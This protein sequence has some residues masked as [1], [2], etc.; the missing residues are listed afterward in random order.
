VA[1]G[2]HPEV[3]EQPGGEATLRSGWAVEASWS[4]IAGHLKS[5]RF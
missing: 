3:G 5:L 4:D 1:R 2:Q